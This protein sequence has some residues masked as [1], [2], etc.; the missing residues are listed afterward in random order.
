[1]NSGVIFKNSNKWEDDPGSADKSL[2]SLCSDNHKIK[3]KIKAIL[4][5]SVNTRKLRLD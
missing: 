1:M 2:Q 3:N 5:V 4:L